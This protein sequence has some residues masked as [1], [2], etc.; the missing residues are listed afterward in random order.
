V[1]VPPVNPA[2]AFPQEL[3]ALGVPFLKLQVLRDNPFERDLDAL[4]AQIRA[5]GYPTQYLLGRRPERSC[6]AR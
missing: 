6:A 3:I 4:S 1:R 2:V 5:L